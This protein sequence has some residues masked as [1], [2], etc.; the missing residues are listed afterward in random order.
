M[1]SQS[2]KRSVQTASKSEGSVA[3]GGVTLTKPGP[4]KLGF[5]AGLSF[6]L[7]IFVTVVSSYS[8]LD[9]GPASARHAS[10][11]VDSGSLTEKD[12]SDERS[13]HLQAKCNE[14]EVIV[15]RTGKFDGAKLREQPGFEYEQVGIVS[16]GDHLI[17]CERATTPGTKVLNVWFRITGGMHDQLWINAQVLKFPRK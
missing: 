5:G 12:S 13:R 6:A 8:L 1:G 14:R 15:V 10:T 7:L 17:V 2:S 11:K 16:R 3:G 4:V 9:S